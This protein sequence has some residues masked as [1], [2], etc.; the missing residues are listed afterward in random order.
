MLFD[1]HFATCDAVNA[2][3]RRRR[4]ISREGPLLHPSSDHVQNDIFARVPA[5]SVT[6]V[7]NERLRSASL[8]M[9]AITAPRPRSRAGLAARILQQRFFWGSD[10]R[11][12]VRR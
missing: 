9:S 1:A 8:E 3:K 2:L 6:A 12:A 4:V 11:A 7:R 5:I 10:R